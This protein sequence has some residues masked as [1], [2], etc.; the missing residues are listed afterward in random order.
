MR[1]RSFPV[2][3]CSRSTRS[4][5]IRAGRVSAIPTRRSSEVGRSPGFKKVTRPDGDTAG[6][7]GW[8]RREDGQEAGADLKARSVDVADPDQA[9]VAPAVVTLDVAAAIDRACI[10]AGR[11]G[12]ANHRAGGNADTKTDTKTGVSLGVST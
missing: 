8:D 10:G 4:F 3:S 11:N 12:R 9:N 7:V 5:G 6:R 2:G 1:H